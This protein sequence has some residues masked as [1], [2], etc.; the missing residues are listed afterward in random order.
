M[1]KIGSKLR[2]FARNE[3]DTGVIN[4]SSSRTALWD[5]NKQY[6]RDQAE[7]RPKNFLRKIEIKTF[8]KVEMIGYFSEIIVQE[9]ILGSNCWKACTNGLITVFNFAVSGSLYSS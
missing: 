7:R 4:L 5:I 9:E 3:G 8:E 1:S 2:E 6:G